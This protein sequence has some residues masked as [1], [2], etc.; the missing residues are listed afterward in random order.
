MRRF[1][2]RR[3]GVRAFMHTSEELIA[4]VPVGGAPL[5]QCLFACDLV[6][7]AASR[8]EQPADRDAR[9]RA[10]AFVDANDGANSPEA[11]P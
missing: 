8:P 3:L 4:V 10:L 7:F 11:A 1:A 6:K 5:R 2:M 9:A